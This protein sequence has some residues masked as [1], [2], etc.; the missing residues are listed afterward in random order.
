MQATPFSFWRNRWEETRRSCWGGSAIDILSALVGV[1]LLAWAGWWIFKTMGRA[2]QQYAEGMISAQ[3]R[4]TEVVCQINM[5]SI[6][7]GLQMAAT[8]EGTYPE[9][10]SDLIRWCGDPRLFHCPDPNGG[11]YRYL[12][13]Q[14]VDGSRVVVL[15]YE[16]NAVHDGRRCVL[17]S[18][19]QIGLLTGD[20][21][22]R[23]L[24]T[25]PRGRR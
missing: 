3:H 16:P 9:S 14:R 23:A 21:F 6:W 11:E 7:Q 25:Q 1:G 20:E 19:G 18:N 5:R 8:S 15:L 10:K 4:S 22:K 13:A 2:G 12:P 24:P 17:L